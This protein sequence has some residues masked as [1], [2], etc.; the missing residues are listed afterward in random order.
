MN[1]RILIIACIVLA[2]II[3]SQ[4]SD[5]TNDL[6][7]R[8]IVGSKLDVVH[9]PER[10]AHF[11]EW[12]PNKT[13]QKRFK[14]KSSYYK[15]HHTYPAYIEMDTLG[16]RRVLEVSYEPSFHWRASSGRLKEEFKKIHIRETLN[17]GK[18]LLSLHIM[19][20]DGEDIYTGV[21]VSAEVFDREAKKLKKVGI[22]TPFF[23]E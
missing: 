4:Y 2:A 7:S 3:F 5:S 19:N 13:Y 21:W 23:N 12:L 8:S 15:R 14:N 10:E 6:S 9:F 20:K 17:R 11:T 16:N 22:E 18:K 1:I